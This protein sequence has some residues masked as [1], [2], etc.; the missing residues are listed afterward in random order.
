MFFSNRGGLGNNMH[1]I[2]LNFPYFI[3]EIV[4]DLFCLGKCYQAV[5]VES[6]L[7]GDCVWLFAVIWLEEILVSCIISFYLFFRTLELSF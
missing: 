6:D 1:P 5:F 7:S 2:V 3:F 4:V